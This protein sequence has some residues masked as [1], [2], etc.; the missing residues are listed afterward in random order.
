M[1]SIRFMM[2]VS[3]I[4]LYACASSEETT[5]QQ[6]QSPKKEPEV[7]V[8]DDVSKVDTLKAEKPK[9]ESKEIKAEPKVEQ[10]VEQK[11]ETPVP[12]STK[13]FIVQVGA[14]T[15]KER[16]QIFIKENQN[17]IEQLMT[18]TQRERDKLFIVQLPAFNTKE[19]AELI[20]NKI[21]QI[22][23]FKDAFIITTE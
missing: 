4:A 9:E 15:T 16:A 12:V 23:A 14:F 2:I 17:K 10:K 18:I 20:R 7:Y 11:V 5:T 21:W 3:M 1:K 19:D 22:P 13:K 6:Q 8:F